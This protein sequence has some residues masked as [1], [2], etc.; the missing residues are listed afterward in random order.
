[1]YRHL[2]AQPWAQLLARPSII[3]AIMGTLMLTLRTALWF[4]YHPFAA[5]ENDDAPILTVIIPAFNEGF[6]VEK[7]MALLLYASIHNP[8]TIV[9]LL[10]VIGAMSTLTMLLLSA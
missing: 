7:S 3:W 2:D 8:L 6:M 5:A 4:R 9:R 1:M 10:F